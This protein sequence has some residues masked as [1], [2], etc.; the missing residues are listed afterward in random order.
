MTLLR[1]ILLTGAALIL[2]LTVQADIT[3]NDLVGTWYSETHDSGETLKRLVKRDNSNNY[4]ELLLICDGKEFSWVQKELGAW[5]VADATT[6]EVVMQSREDMNGKITADPDNS[7][8]SY[9]NVKLEG[10][11]LTYQ[12]ENKEENNFSFKRVDDGYQI[13]CE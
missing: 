9:I 3:Q 11:K 2:P 8:G 7:V 10:D 6:F 4:A 13:R 1:G 5:R 12:Q